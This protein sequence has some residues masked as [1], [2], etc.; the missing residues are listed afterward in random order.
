MA[1]AVD[2]PVEPEVAALLG[3]E[4]GA[5]NSTEVGSIGT[6]EAGCNDLELLSSS[7]ARSPLSIAKAKAKASPTGASAAQATAHPHV[8]SASSVDLKGSDEIAKAI[9]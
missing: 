5:G 1:E 4:G 2:A 8:S 3:T 9:K 6:G 7:K